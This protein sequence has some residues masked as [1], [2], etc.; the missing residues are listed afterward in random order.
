MI[1]NRSVSLGLT[2]PSG[3]AL[4]AGA[5]HDVLG[6]RQHTLGGEVHRLLAG[7]TESIDGGARHFYRETRDQDG[8]PADVQP[9]LSGLGHTADD[10]VVDLG[11]I[12]AGPLHDF[13]Q[14]QRQQVVRPN[15]AQLA[16]APADRGADGF[17]DDGITHGHAPL[18]SVSSAPSQF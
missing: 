7:T 3:H 14:G 18:V 1:S 5:D 9:L 15:R 16:V 10:H 12:D 8:G 11:G 13:A 17:D 2:G 6:A 4:Y